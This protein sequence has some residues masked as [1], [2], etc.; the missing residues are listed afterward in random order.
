MVLMK[1]YMPTNSPDN[2]NTCGN[3][4]CSMPSSLCTII[5]QYSILRHYY[6]VYRT[7]TDSAFLMVVFTCLRTSATYIFRFLVRTAPRVSVLPLPL[8][9]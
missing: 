5:L 2:T 6:H 3:D 4:F 9:S 8:D 1:N 7:L